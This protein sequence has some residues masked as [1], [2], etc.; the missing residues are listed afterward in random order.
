MNRYVSSVRILLVSGLGLGLVPGSGKTQEALPDLSR[1]LETARQVMSAPQFRTAIEYVEGSEEETIREWL[2]LCNAYG[3]SAPQTAVSG[4]GWGNEIYRSRLL[5][6]LFRIYGLEKVHID[7]ALNVIGVRPGVGEGPT[8][9][10]NSH[11]DNVALWP[12]DQ[13]IEAFVADDR[14]W[15][16][17][18]GDDLM[19]TTQLLTVLRAMN[20]A[21][22]ET[23]GDVWFVTLTGEEHGSPGSEQFVRGNY[24]HNIDWRR[25]DVM[26]Q[27]HGGG[28]DGVTTGSTPYSFR[29]ILRMFVP[30]GWDRWRTDA[31]DVL[32]PVITRI[33]EEIRDPRSLGVGFYEPG[34]GDMTSEL[35]Y[36]NMGMVQGNVIHNG[37][38]DQ[39]WIRL[40]L[41]S[42]SY[43]RVRRAGADIERIAAE[44]C[45]ELGEGCTYTFE[46]LYWIGTEGID[47]WDKLNN[48]PARMAAAAAQT[49][50]GVTPIIEPT[51]GCGDCR[52]AYMG[53]MPAM[54]L[55]GN[56]A[57]YGG[58][59]FE[60]GR[61][62]SGLQSQTRR[63]SSGHDVTESGEILRLWSGIK[64]GLLFA[65]SYAGL[66]N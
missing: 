6:K 27:F 64:H 18:A 5:Y 21:N 41:R 30:L 22:I 56:V 16:P 58:G 57:D 65:V 9:V 45:Q 50:Y 33:N 51:R 1:E 61:R 24:P 4:R 36:M 14:V 55:R 49:L 17:A 42:P 53:G 19:G 43:E 44:A 7:D 66:A 48:A 23:Q 47:G 2:S 15:C 52:R 28:G 20:A 37:T 62:P 32:G 8:V 11:H 25:G 13:P 54:S 46:F 63:V 29:A 39:A 12:Q 26:I 40:D 3:P 35:L 34:A 31:V 10:L 59:R 38:S 60:V